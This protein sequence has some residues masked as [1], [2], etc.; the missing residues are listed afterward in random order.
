MQNRPQ[1]QQTQKTYPDQST[2]FLTKPAQKAQT[3]YGG[4]IGE[5]N[6]A[7]YTFEETQRQQKELSEKLRNTTNTKDAIKLIEEYQQKNPYVGTRQTATKNGGVVAVQGVDIFLKLEST[8][9]TL[10]SSLQEKMPTVTTEKI[11]DLVW[12]IPDPNNPGKN[13]TYAKPSGEIV[14]LTFR[15]KETAEKYFSRKFPPM[16]T[17]PDP[18][19]PGKNLTY[20]NSK[21]ITNELQFKSQES[22]EKYISRA[23]IFLPIIE[24][25]SELETP[26]TFN[27][28]DEQGKT[29]PPTIKL[30]WDKTNQYIETQVQPPTKSD[31]EF[32]Q[33]IREVL[34]T[35]P[36]LNIFPTVT[37]SKNLPGVSIVP[38]VETLPELKAIPTDL[39][40]GS[41][42]DLFYN[43]PFEKSF[44]E[45][46]SELHYGIVNIFKPEGEK[47]KYSPTLE[48]SLYSDLDK[49]AGNLLLKEHNTPG[50]DFK[51]YIESNLKTPE[52]QQRIAGSI[53]GSLVILGASVIFPPLASE[54]YGRYI[55]T[56]RNLKRAE[57]LAEKLRYPTKNTETENFISKFPDMPETV[58][59]EL[60]QKVNDKIN[61]G[62]ILYHGTT[63]EQ[64][65][66]II[67]A[68]FDSKPRDQ[69]IGKIQAIFTTDN[70]KYAIDYAI[71]RTRGINRQYE[72]GFEGAVLKITMKADA[73]SAR[74]EDLGKELRYEGKPSQAINAIE[75][76]KK[77]KLDF[78]TAT[79]DGNIVQIILNPNSI[80][81]IEGIEGGSV[82][83][84]FQNPNL[85]THP[86]REV[87]VEMLDPKTALF[88]IGT[89]ADPAQ[90][91]FIIARYKNRGSIASLYETPDLTKPG[92]YKE[93]LLRGKQ[94]NELYGGIFVNEKVTSYPGFYFGKIRVKTPEGYARPYDT[95]E[96][97][98]NLEIVETSQELAKIG[99][100]KD[101]LLSDLEKYPHE[102]ILNI[103]NQPIKTGSILV[104]TKRLSMDPVTPSKN[105]VGL[106]GD[107]YKGDLG[108]KDFNYDVN[109]M[110]K[111][112]GEISTKLPGKK[113]DNI[114]DDIIP[115]S[116]QGGT[117]GTGDNTI[118]E[119]QPGKTPNIDLSLEG[120]SPGKTKNEMDK[121][122]ERITTDIKSEP[123]SIFGFQSA[124]ITTSISGLK[125]ETNNILEQGSKLGEKS[126]Q[127]FKQSTIN[128]LDQKQSEKL[129]LDEQLEKLTTV[130]EIL[131]FELRQ[132][133]DERSILDPRWSLE[134]SQENKEEFIFKP[135]F[136]LSTK[137]EQ[138]TAQQHDPIYEEDGKFKIPPGVGAGFSPIDF[139]SNL[140]KQNNSPG[141]K[142][143]LGFYRWNTNTDQPGAYL[144]VADITIGKTGKVIT[145]IDRLEK[146]T[147]NPT[148]KHV[149]QQR[150]KEE[151]YFRTNTKDH[152]FK[153]STTPKARIMGVS[154]PKESTELNFGKSFEKKKN[155]KPFKIDF[156]F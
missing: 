72:N 38:G 6:K 64:A 71:G 59:N 40:S 70:E 78:V 145:I 13:M 3:I 112:K 25:K 98:R 31:I 117:P 5:S 61:S 48:G 101:V 17:I 58:K 43:H 108:R 42:R 14:D 75:L 57:A 132:K 24:T 96:G 134:V 21:G 99:I 148:K 83:G 90:T 22:A 150:R 144:D 76:A 35:D 127:G 143:H 2:E 41:V 63:K 133:Q 86:L 19:N 106:T 110:K 94:N 10:E 44:L 120:K 129:K 66:K 153:I 36:N 91:S 1:P 88:S 7:V 93:I 111:G 137:L 81:K 46:G 77:R 89:E 97:Y 138:A 65:D 30:L 140:K 51:D 56:P 39:N 82:K 95:T 147:N 33:H 141:G 102:M 123:G 107:T 29:I 142:I 26:G 131:S 69:P 53:A 54:T 114:Y 103:E 27:F 12:T 119:G 23:G 156:G 154:T 28:V 136:D 92:L 146:K 87:G 116:K 18:N 73:I 84:V 126:I 105:Y 11:N 45:H 47:I 85:Y 32:N 15:S 125:L 130:K 151:T 122:K 124:L 149:E 135:R 128:I 62:S 74:M 155:S 100:K 152:S 52:G 50:S 121:L 113:T 20:T 16:W 118:L 104:E 8:K 37:P 34:K 80:K 4:S 139:E 55:L 9:E 79:E 109:I 68:G 49:S 60:R 67:Q 115:N